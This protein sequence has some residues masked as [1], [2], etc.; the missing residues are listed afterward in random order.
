MEPIFAILVGLFF[1]VA[2]YLLLSKFIIRVLLGVAILGNAVNLLIF[3]SGRILR[4]V[5]PVIGASLDMSV[6]PT[7][8]PLPQALIL[9]AIVI[10]FSFFSFLLVLSW[11]AY[12]VLETDNTD[13]MRVAEPEGD[14][15]PPLRY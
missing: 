7:A 11:R 5:P 12:R 15:P 8:N 4:D 14:A 3:A 9:T 10:S 1:A 6:G 13:E 2:V